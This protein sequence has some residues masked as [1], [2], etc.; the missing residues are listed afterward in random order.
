MQ[1]CVQWRFFG[2]GHRT[3][4]QKSLHQFDVACRKFYVRWFG[5][6]RTL[7]GHA[8]GMKFFM[9]GMDKCNEA[10]EPPVLVYCWLFEIHFAAVPHDRWIHG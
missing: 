6:F 5:H 4:H 7:I 8:P 1:L 2:Y 10:L 9:I 3:V